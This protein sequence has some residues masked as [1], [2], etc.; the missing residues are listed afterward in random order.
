MSISAAAVSDQNIF[1]FEPE[2]D[3]AT[4]RAASD[5]HADATRQVAPDPLRARDRSLDETA[6]F[7]AF[8]PRR[9]SALFIDNRRSSLL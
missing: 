9:S 4:I 1:E 8:A 7:D 5:P 2:R 3:T 6:D